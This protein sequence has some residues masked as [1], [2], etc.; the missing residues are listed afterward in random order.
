M[1]YTTDFSG[2]FETNKPLSDKMFNYLKMFS[3]TRRMARNMDAAYGVEGE[4]FVEGKGAFGQDSDSTVI[5][6]NK[7]ASTQP[8]LWCQWTPSDDRMGIEW[9]GGEKFYNYTEWLVY[10]IHKIL[11]PNGYVL[12]GSVKWQ[13]EEVGDVGKIIVEDNR[14]FTEPWE[15]SMEEHTPQNIST[16]SYPS[17]KSNY[18]QT[19]TVL[20]VD[21]IE[22]PLLEE[23][24]VEAPKEEEDMVKKFAR[25]LIIHTN[26]VQNTAGACRRYKRK[27]YNVDELFDIFEGLQIK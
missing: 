27:V 10:L 3:E 5:N 22:Q 9:D 4:F 26:E 18:M 24:K 11:A 21:S 17:N 13:G 15:G 12:N 6:H 14:V 7:P 2:R 19:E 20:I 1:G 23:P 8:G 25:W 16:Y